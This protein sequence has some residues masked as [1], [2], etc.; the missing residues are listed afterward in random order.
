MRARISHSHTM[1]ELSPSPPAALV[2]VVSGTAAT[3]VSRP[4][5]RSGHP[6]VLSPLSR[7]PSPPLRQSCHQRQ[8]GNPLQW[9]GEVH[10]LPPPSISD[11]Q[12]IVSSFVSPAS[13]SHWS[14]RSHATS[15]VTTR[16]RASATDTPEPRGK[17]I[18]DELLLRL[19]MYASRLPSL[20][21]VN[22]LAS[23][24]FA[25]GHGLPADSQCE[26]GFIPVVGSGHRYGYVFQVVDADL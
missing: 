21:D 11:E 7:L 26:Q 16:S 5:R 13:T 23:S 4:L 24:G 6:P 14:W 15:T 20:P 2:V 1:P 25:R 19:S 3:R 12:F 22:A 9:P 17:D 10:P 8:H 18:D